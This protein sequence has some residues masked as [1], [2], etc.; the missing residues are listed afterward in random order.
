MSIFNKGKEAKECLD[1][2]KDK[3][4]CDECKHWLDKY[5]LQ[6]VK[7]YSNYGSYESRFCPLHKKPY[8]RR[9]SSGGRQRYFGELEITEDGEPVGYKKANPVLKT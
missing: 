5:D 7:V 6:V 4:K 9:E 8:S 1:P 2:F 3:G